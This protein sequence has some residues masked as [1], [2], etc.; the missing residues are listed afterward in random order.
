ME[1]KT[2]VLMDLGVTCAS[3]SLATIDP[4]ITN[5]QHTP[6]KMSKEKSPM[7]VLSYRKPLLKPPTNTLAR[8]S[9]TP[10]LPLLNSEVS[11]PIVSA[12]G[13]P[14][15]GGTR[16]VSSRRKAL[17]EFYKLQE[18]ESKKADGN[19]Q[20]GENAAESQATT[21]VGIGIGIGVGEARADAKEGE[22]KEGAPSSEI[23]V[24]SLSDP[25]QLEKYIN[26]AT[27]EEMLK[28]RNKAA[29]R[30]NH[31][32]IEKKSIIYDN[33]YELIKLSQ[34][35]SNLD[36]EKTAK[37][38]V[39]DETDNGPKVSDKYVHDVLSEFKSFLAGE[40]AV[41]NKD[42][43]LVVDTIRAGVDDAD[44]VASVQGISGKD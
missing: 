44:S 6:P 27:I 10:Q 26:S 9:P 22:G 20:D 28:L 31:H 43:V 24:Q 38:R 34:V 2:R 40:G 39:F 29:G 4:H 14:T 1:K 19:N 36:A 15:L 8:D 11:S 37:S 23:D 3:A 17:Q 42:F 33:Y 35:L 25:A 30:L 21:D 32:D 12:P 18:A 7:P 16:K 13:T 5:R 41:F